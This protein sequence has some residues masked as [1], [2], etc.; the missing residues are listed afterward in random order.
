MCSRC[1]QFQEGGGSPRPQATQHSTRTGTPPHSLST[2]GPQEIPEGTGTLTV[3][4]LEP[5]TKALF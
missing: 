2:P 1:W 5:R 3:R 4:T